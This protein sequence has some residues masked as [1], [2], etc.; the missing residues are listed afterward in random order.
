MN[1]QAAK[2][3]V[4][5]MRRDLRKNRPALLRL[6]RISGLPHRWITAFMEGAIRE[7]SFSRISALGEYLGIRVVTKP[8]KHFNDFTPG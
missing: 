1:S 5:A 3:V 8:G 4:E 6:S 2:K 7:P